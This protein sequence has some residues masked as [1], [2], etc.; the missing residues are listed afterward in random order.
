MT[1]Q[2][3]SKYDSKVLEV[4]KPNDAGWSEWVKIEEI[5]SSGLKW[6]DNGNTRRGKP[7]W[8][9]ISEEYV[10]EFKRLNENKTGQVLAVRM[11]GKDIESTIVRPSI[12]ADLEKEL[13]NIKHCNISRLPA[14]NLEIDHR[15]GYKNHPKYAHVSSLKQQ[16]MSDFQVI[17][18]E[19]NLKKREICKSCIQTKVRYKHPDKEFPVGNEIL[20][21]INVCD[22]CYLAYPEQYR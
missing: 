6:G 3:K 21:N 20:D 15:C 11:A 7:P 4:F 16:S 17:T 8:G 19:L 9:K 18:R 10:W 5:R 1:K 22:G 13:K 2:R 12:R 14:S